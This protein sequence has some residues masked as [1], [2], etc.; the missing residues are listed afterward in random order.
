MIA[1][2]EEAL[3]C[4]FAETY[5]IYDYKELPVK[6][7]AIL[8]VGLR[9]DS[10]IKSKMG[11]INTTLNLIFLAEIIDAIHLLVWFKTEDGVKNENRPV[12][13]VAMFDEIEESDTLT[14][15]S[16]EEFEQARKEILKMIEEADNA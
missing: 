13:W 8:A 11:G 9:D 5:H 10:R 12:S 14:Y 4:D 6:Q 2:D 1:Y 7:C 3:I 16:P 15:D